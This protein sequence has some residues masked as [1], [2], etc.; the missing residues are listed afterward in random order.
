VRADQRE[1]VEMAANGI[2][3]HLPAINGMAILACRSKLA[4]M[5]VSVTIST[6]L[7]NV[8]EEFLHVAGITCDILVEAA[9]RIPSLAIVIELD[10]LP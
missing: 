5:D 9:Q 10:R 3:I 8:G 1:A 6:L 4:A 7:T 2:D